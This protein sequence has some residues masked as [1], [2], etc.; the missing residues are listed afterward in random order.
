MADQ[1]IAYTEEMVGSGHPTKSDTLNRHA[2][3]SHETDGTIKM[4]D[5]TTF[6]APTTKTIVAGVATVT[7][8]G[9]FLI[10]TE[11]AAAT[12]DLDK[13]AGLAAGEVVII[14]AAN[15][16]RTI[17]LKQGAYLKLGGIDFSLNNA[18][19]VAVLQCVGSDICIAWSLQNNGE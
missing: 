15:D 12:D 17:V 19:D 8:P 10:D 7:G 2:L 18:Y 4:F 3:V 11:G 6:A 1:T 13:I 9:E 5:V 16:A 14:K